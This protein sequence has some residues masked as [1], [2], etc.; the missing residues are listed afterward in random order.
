MANQNLPP[1]TCGTCGAVAM[2]TTPSSE[3]RCSISA[4]LLDLPSDH[5]APSTWPP[6]KNKTANAS[7]G[8]PLAKRVFLFSP[9]A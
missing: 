2:E 3:R 7:P 8:L 9:A 6:G 4:G 5:T 1:L